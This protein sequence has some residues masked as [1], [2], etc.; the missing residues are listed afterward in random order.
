MRLYVRYAERGTETNYVIIGTA[1][2][3]LR[4]KLEKEHDGP[5][6]VI[7]KCCCELFP[8]L[9]NERCILRKMD[10]VM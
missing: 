9:K 8:V 2:T 6:P 1:Q 3:I 10:V 7:A 4:E 5:K